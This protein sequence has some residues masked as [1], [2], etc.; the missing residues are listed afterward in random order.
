MSSNRHTVSITLAVAATVL[1]LA[2]KASASVS[3]YLLAG[4]IEIVD[5]LLVARAQDR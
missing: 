3:F 2:D 5:A 1:A 4:A